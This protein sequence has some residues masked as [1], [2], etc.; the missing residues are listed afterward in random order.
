MSTK[1]GRAPSDY[2]PKAKVIE[3]QRRMSAESNQLPSQPVFLPSEPLVDADSERKQE[4]INSGIGSKKVAT[5]L[6]ILALIFLGLVIG[7]IVLF[8][9]HLMIPAFI[10]LGIS[11]VSLV[12]LATLVRKLYKNLVNEFGREETIDL[13]FSMAN[14]RKESEV[15]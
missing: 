13:L 8:A 5:R 3:A 7:S 9:N 15:N 6:T 14:P 11:A 10:A 4:I 1:P 12:T 2:K